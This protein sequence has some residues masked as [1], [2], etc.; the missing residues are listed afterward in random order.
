[1]S[2]NPNSVNDRLDQANKGG[3]G[4]PQIDPD[5]QRKYMGTFRERVSLAIPVKDVGSIFAQKA[6]ILDIKKH[7]NYVVF[8]NQLSSDDTVNYMKIATKYNADFDMK[9]GYPTNSDSY[10]ILLVNKNTAINQAPILWNRK[11]PNVIPKSN[12]SKKETKHS[13]G[14]WTK[15]KKLF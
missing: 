14:F 4:S 1:M 6:L 12:N 11:Y 15:V 3:G 8:I 10:G 13:E 5:Q 2:A 9:T 7:P